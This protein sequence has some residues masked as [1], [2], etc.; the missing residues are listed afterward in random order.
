MNI[1]FIIILF[2]RYFQLKS[3]L[4]MSPYF[5]VFKLLWLIENVLEV[6]KA[7]KEERCMF[8]TMDS[9]I[10]WVTLQSNKYIVKNIDT[11]ILKS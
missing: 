6:E 10:I 5:S 1:I 11:F 8:G 3:G 7:I 2:F 9:W 4:T